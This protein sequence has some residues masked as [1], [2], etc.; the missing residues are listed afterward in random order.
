MI[1]QAA[2]KK[3]PA[4]WVPTLYVAEGLPFIATN[5]VS[6]L[7]YKSLGLS[8]AKIALF[9]SFLAL[10]WSLKFVWSPFMEMYRTKKFFVVATEFIG[11]TAFASLALS[12]SNDAFVQY[13]LA[14]FALIAVSSATHDIAADGLYIESL[15]DAEQARWVG[16]QGACWNCGKILAQGGLVKIAGNLEKSMG[17]KVAWMIVMGLFGALLALF[18]FYHAT[19]LPTGKRAEKVKTAKDVVKE[20]GHVI[21]T[22]FQKKHVLWGL[23]FVLFYRFAEGQAQKI[24]PLFLR[25]DRAAGGLGLSTGDVGVAY[26]T[27]GALAFISGSILGGYFS[28]RVGLKRALLPLCAIFNLPYLAYLFLVWTKPESF[29]ITTAAISLEMFGY[30]FGFVGITLFMMQQIATGTYKMAHYAFATSAMGFGMMLPGTWSG[31]LSDAIG[32]KNFFVWVMASTALS[33]TAT[34]LVPFKS[35]QEIA[36]ENEAAAAGAQAAA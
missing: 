32:Y 7:M 27:F 17:P 30:G 25:A 16:W 24:F 12:L 21:A 14:F 29:T 2:K 10:P 4:L 33:F 36:A 34:W 28:A 19:F 31:Y 5:V 11:G 13:S 22:F 8:D 6:V 1:E 23:A 20:L 18:S 35:D 15:S 9:T 3:R 26:G